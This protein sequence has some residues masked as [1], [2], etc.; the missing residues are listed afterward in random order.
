[1]HAINATTAMFP[2]LSV[3]SA[4][5]RIAAGTSEPG[6][7]PVAS[8]HVQLCPQSMGCLTESVCESLRARYPDMQLR[9]HANARVLPRHHLLDAASFG[10]DTRFYYEA[11][12][13]R[14]R[15][16]GAQA[17][18]LHAGKR[19]DASLAVMFDN[20]RRIQ[21]L[22]G[23]IT[24]AIEGLYPTPEGTWLMQDWGEYE[25]AHRA[26]IPLALDLSHLNIVRAHGSATDFANLPQMLESANTIEVHVSD[27]DGKADRHATLT[28]QPWWW[29]QLA[30]IHSDAVVFTEGNHLRVQKPAQLRAGN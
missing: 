20:A 22:F 17:Y 13:D 7:G 2:T 9:L 28:H 4:L 27:N 14:S 3:H 25:A 8:S 29:P 16:L 5:E 12:A 1:M 30:H 11:L 10:E 19:R 23:D 15:R 18:S 24:V 6:F 26:G 21:D